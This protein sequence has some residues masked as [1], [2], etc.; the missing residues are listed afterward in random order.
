MLHKILYEASGAP[1]GTVFTDVLIVSRLK[2]R[3]L[4]Q[5]AYTKQTLPLIQ[6]GCS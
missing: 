3:A 5:L 6:I 2:V 1:S 4:L